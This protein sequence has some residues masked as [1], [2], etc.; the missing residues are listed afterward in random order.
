MPITTPDT[1]PP[2]MQAFIDHWTAVNSAISPTVLSLQGGYVVATFTT[3]RTAIVNGLGA[4]IVADNGRQGAK[5]TLD[6]RK[7]AMRIRLAQ[8]RGMVLAILPGTKYASMLPT[9]PRVDAAESKFLAP[10][11]DAANVWLQINTDTIPGFTGP[12]LL[13]GGY[14]LAN[15]NSDITAMRG[16]YIA[17]TQALNNASGSRA[18]RDLL[19]APAF[20]RMKQYRLAAPGILPTGSALLATIPALS[21]NLGPPAQKV[22]PTIHWDSGINK[23][24]ITWTASLSTDVS[25]YAIRTAPGPT[26]RSREESTVGSVAPSVL[27]FATDEGLSASG[28]TA[29]FKVYTVTATGREAGSIVL[30]ITRP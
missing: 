1:Y 25:E 28:A 27:T 20:Q 11:T 10:F 9:L 26:Y 18:N 24:V 16:E 4:V 17:Y 29:I 30:R 21:P 5:A 7:A 6:I 8:F 22:N 19:L 23:A 2:V 14:T 13:A 15:F 12:L 3:D